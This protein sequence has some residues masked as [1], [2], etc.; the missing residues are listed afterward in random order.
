MSPDD[1]ARRRYWHDTMEEGWRF[2]QLIRTFDYRDSGERMVSLP[3]AFGAAGVSL[4]LPSRQSR[5][6]PEWREPEESEMYLRQS[7]AERLVAVG[8][9]LVS[10]GLRLTVEY[11]YRRAETQAALL[12]SGRVL[13]RVIRQTAFEVAG[14][15]PVGLVRRRLCVIVAA[16]PITAPHLAGSAVD[17]NICRADGAELDR[18]GEYVTVNECTPMKSPFV[19]EEARRNRMLVT[20]CFLRRGFIAHPFEFWHYSCRDV[21]DC[22]VTGTPPAFL[23]IEFDA[24]TGK[25]VP[26]PDLG[27][28][29]F[30]DA[31]LESAIVS[32]MEVSRTVTEGNRG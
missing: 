10:L 16:W 3:D 20:D 18:G 14:V 31:D 11:A 21:F 6:D 30:S 29:F 27:R 22:A 25:V 28:P 26:I 19:D 15:P 13:D 4:G 5:V 8:L 9:D 32:R 17:V 12:T 24:A 1:T 2:M 7:V 23:P